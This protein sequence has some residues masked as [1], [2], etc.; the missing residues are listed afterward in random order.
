MVNLSAQGVLFNF[1]VH[2]DLNFDERPS[3]PT[4][5]VADAHFHSFSEQRAVLAADNQ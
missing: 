1:H 3:T 4:T 5:V 2:D